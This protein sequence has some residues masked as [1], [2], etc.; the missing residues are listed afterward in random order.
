MESSFAIIR[1]KLASWPSSVCPIVRT[2]DVFSIA[3][4]RAL[5]DTVATPSM[6]PMDRLAALR[7]GIVIT[8]E[9]LSQRSR[10][11]TR[12]LDRG[13]LTRVDPA[14]I[15]LLA[16]GPSLSRQNLCTGRWAA[17]LASLERKPE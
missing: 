12:G 11:Q 4:P 5:A 17:S 6:E 15:K 8:I 9:T 13:R 2:T 7:I 1:R 16:S 3:H 14:A 10:W